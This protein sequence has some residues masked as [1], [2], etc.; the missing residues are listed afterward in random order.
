MGG[1]RKLYR[2]LQ[3]HSPNIA[4]TIVTRQ[5]TN[6]DSDSDSATIDTHPLHIPITHISWT[7]QKPLSCG[8]LLTS[9]WE[10]PNALN[11]LKAK[12]KGLFKSKSKKPAEEKKED[13][14]PTETTNGAAPTETAPA[15]AEPAAA[16]KWS[17]DTL[18]YL[19][20]WWRQ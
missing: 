16:R 17:C 8:H 19:T 6:A 5:S 10:A 13:V 2:L 20:Y 18:A 14:K 12:L 1:V 9:P 11:D 7:I 4:W 3:S 15:A